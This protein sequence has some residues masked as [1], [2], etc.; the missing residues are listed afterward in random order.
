[1]LA[2]KDGL[3]EVMNLKEVI[4]AFINFREIVITRRTIYLLNK[5]RDKNHILLRLIIA[6]SNIDEVIRII[7][8]S[9]DP[10]SAKEQLMQRTWDAST[11]INLVK[12]VDDR[13]VIAEMVTVILLKHRQKLFLKCGYNV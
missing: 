8:S 11:I 1:M 2:L 3:P 6:V 4:A 10:A 7:K 9:S 12:L 5:A 13:A